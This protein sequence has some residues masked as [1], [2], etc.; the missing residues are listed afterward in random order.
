MAKANR[1]YKGDKLPKGVTKVERIGATYFYVRVDDERK[2]CGKDDRGFELARAARQKYEYR[3][4]ID[5]MYTT[6]QEDEAKRLESRLAEFKTVTAMV[7]YL[8]EKEEGRIEEK[9]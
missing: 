3:K 5:R 2:Y 4:I 6:G 8:M 7:N 1:I 9:K